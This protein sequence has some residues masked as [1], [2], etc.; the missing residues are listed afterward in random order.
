MAKKFW[1]LI[2][3]LPL[4]LLVIGSFG[5]SIYAAYNK[6]SGITYA[7][8]VVLGAVIIL[9]FLGAWLRSGEDSDQQVTESEY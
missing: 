3:E 1:G 6:I 9:Y 4:I 7:S 5:A 8:S 2:L